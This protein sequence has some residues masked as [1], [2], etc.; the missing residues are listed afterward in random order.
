MCYPHV[1]IC[2]NH[3]PKILKSSEAS[4]VLL[5]VYVGYKSN[6]VFNIFV[7]SA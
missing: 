7:L 1:F 6:F 4:H 2:L 5:V 3:S